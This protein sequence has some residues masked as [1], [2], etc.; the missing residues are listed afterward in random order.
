AWK[1]PDPD[2][3]ALQ[4][5]L[6]ELGYVEGR[7]IVFEIRS[8]EGKVERHPD[9]AAELVRLKVDLILVVTCGPQL[10]AARGATSTIPILV[11]ACSDDMVES[12]I[13]A[14]LA[15]PGGNITGFQKLNPELAAKRLELLKEAIPK[16]SRVAVL[17]NPGYSDF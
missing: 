15:H 8:A 12:G 5:G 1:S 4:Q 13:V 3:R 7:N 17:W 10:N 14:S 16:M 6:R 11:I 2:D 9:L